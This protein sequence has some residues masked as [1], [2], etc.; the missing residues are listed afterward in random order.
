MKKKL[1]EKL[2]PL[3]FATSIALGIQWCWTNRTIDNTTAQTEMLVWEQNLYTILDR[4]FWP[5]KNQNNTNIETWKNIDLVEKL[6]E[7]QKIEL[8]NIIEKYKIDE[9]IN[10]LKT[11]ISNWSFDIL[12][13][14]KTIDFLTEIIKENK[15]KINNWNI[16]E[17]NW[18]I[19]KKDL[20]IEINI[21]EEINKILEELK[22]RLEQNSDNMTIDDFL[23]TPEK[24]NADELIKY[25][26]MIKKFTE[27]NDPR[28]F[29]RFDKTNFSNISYFS[30]DLYIKILEQTEKENYI[31]TDWLKIKTTLDEKWQIQNYK[32]EYNWN[33]YEIKDSPNFPVI[34]NTNNPLSQTSLNLN[35]EELKNDF[36]GFCN[37]KDIKEDEIK[38]DV[39]KVKKLFLDF[40]Y[41]K[42]IEKINEAEEK[43]IS[44]QENPWM[45]WFPKIN[46]NSKI[47]VVNITDGEDFLTKFVA[48]TS[49]DWGVMGKILKEKWYKN[50]T[51]ENISIINDTINEIENKIPDELKAD[52]I[53]YFYN[54]KT[55]AI[56]NP[57]ISNL[58]P[59][60]LIIQKILEASENWT[61]LLFIYTLNHGSEK[62]SFFPTWKMPPE[63]WGL[64]AKITSIL[65]TTVFINNIWCHSGWI[66]ALSNIKI[67]WAKIFLHTQS[68]TNTNTPVAYNEN[69]Q[70]IWSSYFNMMFLEYLWETGNIQEAIKKANHY[71]LEKL[72]L[73]W[74]II[75]FNEDWIKK[76]RKK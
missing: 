31:N 42:I 13:I 73:N 52:F 1:W 17:E 74:V 37:K 48:K 69:N 70:M 55:R 57:N 12:K 27:E 39:N 18:D 40:I 45:E 44:E 23:R 43:W 5:D 33:E 32:F 19:S 68:E 72:N 75:S 62:F 28:W 2:A 58:K 41:D 47:N 66:D 22:T 36:I 67:P 10:F 15:E 26:T 6:N 65:N 35:F 64:I 7:L 50:V 63:L 76:T 34:V 30:K 24:L 53:K 46:E 8:D 38:E 60:L 25:F 49:P 61:E 9:L 29:P 71:L 11:E 3:V 59:T 54:D 14:E 4:T 51:N 21:L 56:L 16:S 20:E